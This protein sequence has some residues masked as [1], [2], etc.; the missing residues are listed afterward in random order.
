LPTHGGLKKRKSK[1]LSRSIERHAWGSG[2]PRIVDFWHAYQ[3]W[4]QGNR[5]SPAG[6]QTF[7]EIG[8]LQLHGGFTTAITTV[9]PSLNL[10]PAS[11]CHIG[12]KKERKKRRRPVPCHNAVKTGGQLVVLDLQSPSKRKPRVSFYTGLTVGKGADSTQTEEK[13]SAGC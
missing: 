1:L 2:V 8:G 12:W 3:N 9:V 5:S 11:T 13:D 6:R 7:G 10:A 4:V